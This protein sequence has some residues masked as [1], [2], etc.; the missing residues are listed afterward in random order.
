MRQLYELIRP[1]EALAYKE[2]LNSTALSKGLE[3]RY[4]VSYRRALDPRG[5]F[6]FSGDSLEKILLRLVAMEEEYRLQTLPGE[7]TEG[8]YTYTSLPSE[9]L[10][11]LIEEYQERLRE[12]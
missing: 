1:G 4:K 3:E 5:I 8:Q 10:D 2:I 9:E 7:L 6:S 12:R 11:S